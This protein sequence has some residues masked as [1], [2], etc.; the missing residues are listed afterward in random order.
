MFTESKAIALLPPQVVGPGITQSATWSPDGKYLLIHAVETKSMGELI[1]HHILNPKAQPP[2]VPDQTISIYD[3]AKQT[4]RTVWKGKIDGTDIRDANWLPGNGA[5]LL[6]VSLVVKNGD[7]NVPQQIDALWRIPVSGGQITTLYQAQDQEHLA[8]ASDAQAKGSILIIRHFDR[9]EGTTNVTA[10]YIWINANGTL[11]GTISAKGSSAFGE[12]GF[13]FKGTRPM[14][15]AREQIPDRQLKAT[16][17]DMDFVSGALKATTAPNLRDEIEPEPDF[18]LQRGGTQTMAIDKAITL[19]AAWLVAKEKSPQQSAL[20]AAE[21]DTM[22]L[23]PAK[24]AVFYTTKG[25]GMVRQLLSMPKE[26]A[27]KALAEA[28]KAK[29]MSDAKQVATALHI[30]AADYDDN[31]PSNGSD[32]MEALYPYTKNRQMMDGFVYTFNGGNLKDIENPSKTVLG[33]KD[34]PGGKAVAYADGHV[35]WVP[36]P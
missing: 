26:L 36:N 22:S 31:L 6:N 13:F 24:N 15:I 3:V 10:K 12:V 19:E 11:G 21:V 30:Y 18:R 20:V 28:E 7:P 29:I 33:Y 34:G 35:V 14:L 8:V 5:V 25:V 17:H 2:T 16:W 23:S 1:T 32:W 27:M 9:Q 4:S